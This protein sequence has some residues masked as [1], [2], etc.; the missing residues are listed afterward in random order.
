[1]IRSEDLLEN[2]GFRNRQFDLE[3]SPHRIA[4]GCVEGAAGGFH[5][6]AGDRKPETAMGDRPFIASPAAFSVWLRATWFQHLFQNLVGEA[7][8]VVFYV[9]CDLGTIFGFSAALAE[10]DVNSANRGHRLSSV[11]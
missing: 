2:S 1:M 7:G 4:I 9:Q 5:D 6:R 8:T 10:R 3:A 11:L